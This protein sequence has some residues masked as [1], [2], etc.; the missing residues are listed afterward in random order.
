MRRIKLTL[1]IV[2]VIFLT[3]CFSSASEGAEITSP[4]GWRVHPLTGEWAFHSGIDIGYDSGE[5]IG[6]MNPGQVVYAAWYGGYGYT[7]IIAH[8]NGDY[9]LY[10]HCSQILTKYGSYVRK[11]TVIA[12][13]GST[14][15]S[16]GP[17]LHLEYWH[18]GEYADPIVLWQE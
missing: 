11:G 1:I 8:D 17:H 3:G 6:A 16:T 7:V 12:T 5:P 2:L 18:N 13:V 14:G 4:F 9:T 15:N 10:G